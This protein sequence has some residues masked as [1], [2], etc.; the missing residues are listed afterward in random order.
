MDNRGASKMS[1]DQ[2]AGVAGVA[3]LAGL[4]GSVQ[5]TPRDTLAR[6][7]LEIAETLTVCEKA[8]MSIMEILGIPTPSEGGNVPVVPGMIGQTS[9]LCLF[10]ARI[11]N[12]LETIANALT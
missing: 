10:A 8:S 4:S 5:P 2:M 11:R 3:G 12:R 7:L 1:W 9:E 6:R